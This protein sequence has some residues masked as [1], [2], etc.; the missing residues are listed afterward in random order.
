MPAED[1]GTY[2]DAN[3]ELWERW[4]ALKCTPGYQQ[5]EAF[6][7]GEDHLQDFE[8]DELGDVTNKR[9]LHL[10]C[11]FGLDT[12]SWARRGAIATGVDFSPKAIDQARSLADEAGVRAD[13]ICSDVLELPD[14]LEGTFEIVYTSF[15][16][17]AWLSELDRWAHVV[18]HF[19]VDG[20]TFY[21]AEYHPITLVFDDENETE[22]RLRH[23]YFPRSQ[24][25]EFQI[26]GQSEYGWPYSM[27]AVVSALAGAGL[28]I[29][30]LHEFDFSESQNLRFLRRAED[31]K[32]RLPE[33]QEGELPLLFSLR[34]RKD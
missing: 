30:F 7:R 23:P 12:L 2:R 6:R 28:R 22:P 26:G 9:L 15:G 1:W 5:I 4:T 18:A 3:K 8:I 31:G 17:L 16:V 21:I 13:F 27:G 14:N 25:I 10:Q 29:E 33:N 19:L 32:W 11:H 20:G 24:P 34:A